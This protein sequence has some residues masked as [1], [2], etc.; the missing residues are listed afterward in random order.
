MPHTGTSMK[1]E[2]E[3]EKGSGFLR[4][5]GMQYLRK[6]LAGI[7]SRMSCAKHRKLTA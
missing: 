3:L 6:C 4:G 7:L 2:V 1:G 5:T